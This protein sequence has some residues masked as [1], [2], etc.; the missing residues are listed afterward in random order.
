M[1]IGQLARLTG[2]SPKAIRSYETLG[3]LG[4]VAREGRY[5][6][7]GDDHLRQVRLIRQAMAL[8]LRLAALRP[9]LADATGP[10]WTGIA[11]LIDARRQQLAAEQR[12]LQAQDAQL[13]QVRD[14]ILACLTAAPAPDCAETA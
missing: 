13:A 5:R 1:Y 3:L 14:E 2:A 8:G 4:P 11:A 6:R 12:R 7:Y 9:H 10:D